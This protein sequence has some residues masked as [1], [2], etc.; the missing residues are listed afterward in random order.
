MENELEKIDQILKRLQ[1]KVT[2]C[3]K[4]VATFDQD[5]K[6]IPF[7][8][9]KYLV[10][11]EFDRSQRNRIGKLLDEVLPLARISKGTATTM[12]VDGNLD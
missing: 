3:G 10:A 11:S 8:Y 1:I 6:F 5:A 4:F 9:V 12:K 7:G 2:T